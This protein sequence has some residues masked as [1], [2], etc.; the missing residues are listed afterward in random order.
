MERGPDPPPGELFVQNS[1][2]SLIFVTLALGGTRTKS[3]NLSRAFRGVKGSAHLIARILREAQIRFV[4]DVKM[5]YLVL[6][7]TMMR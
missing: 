5:W 6:E 3:S 7:G 4:F 1:R 2:L